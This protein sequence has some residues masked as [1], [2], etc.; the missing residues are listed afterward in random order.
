MI[1]GNP[2]T[3]D[4]PAIC[5]VDAVRAGRYE[6]CVPHSVETP[7]ISD[8]MSIRAARELRERH[9]EM[10][11]EQRRLHQAEEARLDALFRDDLEKEHGLHGHP[12][13]AKVFDL[14][15]SDSHSEGREAVAH[16][17]EELAEL[18]T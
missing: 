17:Y 1:R 5:V 13:S 11:R 18:L 12:K 8:E 3:V 15:W 6:N 14:A 16:R 4:A 9:V 10:R 7:A 2:M